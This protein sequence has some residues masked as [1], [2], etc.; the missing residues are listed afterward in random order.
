[1]LRLNTILDISM[2]SVNLLKKTWKNLHIGTRRLLCKVLQWHRRLWEVATKRARVLPLI[3]R[4]QCIGMVRRR[5]KV[6]LRD[7]MDL[8]VVIRVA[9]VDLQEVLKKRLSYL[10]KHRFRILLLPN[11][12]LVLVIL[13]EKE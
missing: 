3:C 6:M 8:R 10:R 5:N 12:R 9:L 4:M 2:S 11:V 13:T 1:M 7:N